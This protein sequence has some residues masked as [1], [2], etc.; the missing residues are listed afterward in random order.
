MAKEQDVP[1]NPSKISGVCGRLLCCL[2]YE[3]EQYKELRGQLPKIGQVVS[4]PGGSA[5]LIGINMPREMVTLFMIDAQT[6]V[7][8]PAAE[9][10]KQYG[11]V[12]RPSEME[13]EPT[14]AAAPETLGW[15]RAMTPPR[16]GRRRSR[17][18]CSLASAG[19]GAT[20]VAGASR[21]RID[22][23]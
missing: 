9:L 22:A 2:A 1:L 18:G 21:H 5:K 12:V 10:R 4:T 20:A 13:K 8:M 6:V 16:R 7:E 14:E 23:Q 17:P 11:S 3:H 15:T 19:A